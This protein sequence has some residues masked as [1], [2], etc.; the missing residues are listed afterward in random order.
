M[1]EIISSNHEWR[2]SM[3][4]QS[5]RESWVQRIEAYRKS[6]LSAKVWC[7]KN[8]LN[9]HTLRYWIQK[10]GKQKQDTQTWASVSLET[11]EKSSPSPIQICYRDFSIY[12]SNGFLEEDLF[13]T[14][15]VIDSL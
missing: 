11:L 8:N 4:K 13:L 1:F 7:A 3:D 2:F 15:K 12:L 5:L 6:G 10:T 9:V 14:L